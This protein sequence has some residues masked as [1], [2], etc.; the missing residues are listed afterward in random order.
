MSV[1]RPARAVDAI[2]HGRP[3]G[4]QLN[5]NRSLTCNCQLHSNERHGRL[6]DFLRPCL[7]AYPSACLPSCLLPCRHSTLASSRAN[8]D[9][10]F[11][12]DPL[13]ILIGRK[14]VSAH[15]LTFDPQW[16]SVSGGGG[17]GG[18]ERVAVTGLEWGSGRGAGLWAGNLR[19]GSLPSWPTHVPRLYTTAFPMSVLITVYMLSMCTSQHTTRRAMS[20]APPRCSSRSPSPWRYPPPPPP[21]QPPPPPLPAPPTTVAPTAPTAPTA[22]RRSSCPRLRPA[23]GKCCIWVPRCLWPAARAACCPPS[24]WA[25]WP[26]THSCPQS[27]GAL[28]L[29]HTLWEL[30]A[31]ILAITFGTML[32]TTHVL[33]LV[34]G[35]QQVG[36][37]VVN[38][39]PLKVV[40]CGGGEVRR[41]MCQCGRGRGLVLCLPFSLSTSFILPPCPSSVVCFPSP[42]QPGADGAAAASRRRRHR[43]PP[44]R[45]PGDQPLRLDAAGQDHAQHGRWVGQRRREQAARGSKGHL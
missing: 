2:A 15:C 39:K 18:R 21:P 25:T 12:S 7:P 10:D 16:Y 6:A 36:V 3:I 32:L 38:R 13:D 5:D 31:G 29:T 17:A 9:C 45:H 41:S 27:G 19:N 40:G 20:W 1:T 44:G 11:W 26:C 4:R 14:P 28:A 8:L 22:R 24:C 35:I 42:Q 30:R 37:G 33:L 43:L 34:L 23:R